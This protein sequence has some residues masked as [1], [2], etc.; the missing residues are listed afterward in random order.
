MSKQSTPSARDPQASSESTWEK[1]YADFP[2]SFHPHSK[3]FYKV[4]RG[5]R[6]Y[7]GYLRDGWQAAL[8]KYQGQRDDLFAGRTPRTTTDGLTIKDLCNRFLTA[9]QDLVDNGELSP[10]TFRDNKDTTDVIV[11]AF[12]KTRLVS[13]LA[14][15]DFEGLRRRIAKTLGPVALGNTIQRVRGVFKYAFE[16]GLIAAPVRFGPQFKRPKAK[17]MRA[18]RHKNGKKMFDAGE[19]RRM[20]DAAGPQLRAMILLGI[21]CG[22]GNNDCGT[23]PISALD[24]E[25]GW[26]NYARPKTAIARRCPLWPE[27]VAALREVIAS[28]PT[29]KDA[30]DKGLVFITKYGKSWHKDT[31]DNPISKEMRKLLDELGIQRKG[32][33]FYALRHMTETIGGEA[34]DQV[35]LNHIMGHADP[36]MAAVY[37][38]EIGDD[39]LRAVV[40]H[41]RKWLFPTVP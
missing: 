5:K 25:G 13:D 28:R 34:K 32:T 15:D 31:P 27:T 17:V 6:H 35:A 24:L 37:R 1:P 40:E 9:K 41:V 20:L 33:G 30:A 18:E 8:E 7:F 2:L 38:E 19:I 10:R 14:A 36:S 22:F 12:G 16:T 23:L 26:H 21:N 3:R 11:E 4:I 39:R 29:P